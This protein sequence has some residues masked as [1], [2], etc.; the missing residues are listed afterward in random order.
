LKAAA[1][2]GIIAFTWALEPVAKGPVEQLK[3]SRAVGLAKV[4]TPEPV[5]ARLG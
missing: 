2:R 1:R 4:M 5:L 3:M